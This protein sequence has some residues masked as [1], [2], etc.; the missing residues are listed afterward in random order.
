MFKP[1]MHLFVDF[2]K[3]HFEFTSCI[4][5]SC[6]FGPAGMQIFCRGMVYAKGSKATF[7]CTIIQFGPEQTRYA[8]LNRKICA[9]CTKAFAATNFVFD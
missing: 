5:A 1:K 6:L 2:I 7:S 3:K 4:A 9:V 8:A